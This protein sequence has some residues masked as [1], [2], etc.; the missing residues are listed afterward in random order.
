MHNAVH[1]EYVIVNAYAECAVH[2]LQH[3]RIGRVA[4]KAQGETEC[5]IR[6]KI[7]PRVL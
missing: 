4:D 1:V 2:D 6:L 7:T 3:K 5:F